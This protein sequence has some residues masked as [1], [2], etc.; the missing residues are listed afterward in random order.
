MKGT[1][2]KKK[3][4][5]HTKLNFSVKKLGFSTERKRVFHAGILLQKGRPLEI[6]EKINRI[7]I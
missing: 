4:I 1:L 5:W 2:G 7:N 6:N 3:S